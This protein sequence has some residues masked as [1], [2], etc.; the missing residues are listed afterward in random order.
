[1]ILGILY[2]V[3]G[4]LTWIAFA[5]WLVVERGF[6]MDDGE[7]VFTTLGLSFFAGVAWPVTLLIGG[8]SWLVIRGA[9]WF[10]DRE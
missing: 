3:V 2:G 6:A 1:M 5:I 10:E 4:M 9:A 8:V 7:E